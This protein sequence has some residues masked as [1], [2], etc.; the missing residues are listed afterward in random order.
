MA[1][2]PVYKTFLQMNQKQY[3]LRIILRAIE[4][5]SGLISILGGIAAWSYSSSREPERY[6]VSALV[7]ILGGILWLGYSIFP[8]YQVTKQN[9]LLIGI[10]LFLGLTLGLFYTFNFCGGECGCFQYRGYPGYWLKGSICVTSQVASIKMSNW[11]IDTSGLIADIV[12]WTNAGLILSFIGSLVRA[13][14][15][16][17]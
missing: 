13:K 15:I 1:C 6:L 3:L 4:F 5:V 7:M 11:N 12:F 17:T 2:V 10:I 9:S 8:K 16:S 14:K